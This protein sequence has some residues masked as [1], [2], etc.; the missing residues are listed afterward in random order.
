MTLPLH[1]Q[2]QGRS[3][4]TALAVLAALLVLF[5]LYLVGT[6]VW[7]LA[8]FA[9]FVVPAAFD[10]LHNP[11]GRFEMTDTALSWE[12]P[13]LS[14]SVPLARIAKARFDTRWDFSVRVTLILHDGTKLRLPQAVMPPHKPLEEAFK[15]CGVPVERHHFRVI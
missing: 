6:L 12:T 13:R 7:L 4:R 2:T 5:G 8:V 3:L 15:A 14:A 11:Q 10:L 9:L 1:H